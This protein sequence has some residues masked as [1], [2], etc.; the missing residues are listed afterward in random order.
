MMQERQ[1]T[2]NEIMQIY[3]QMMNERRKTM[4]Q[5]HA[6]TM[7][8]NQEIM[9]IYKNIFMRQRQI[10]D[11]NHNKYVSLITESQ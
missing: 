8:T 10:A 6:M 2:M 5:I 9:E 4:A 7:T 3:S 11:A 1:Q